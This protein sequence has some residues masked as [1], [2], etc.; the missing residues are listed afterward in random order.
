MFELGKK[1]FFSRFI[2]SLIIAIQVGLSLGAIN[3]CVL[4]F[5]NLMKSYDYTYTFNDAYYYLDKST[6]EPNYNK[7]FEEVETYEEFQN[8]KSN[9]LSN[10]MDT[11]ILMKDVK[12]D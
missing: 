6:F 4:T 9:D 12:N 5:N 7:N 1:L 2:V 8:K 11:D 10:N 3:Y